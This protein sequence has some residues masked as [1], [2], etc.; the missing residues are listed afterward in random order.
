M[1]INPRNDPRYRVADDYL[2]FWLRF[3]EPSVADITRGRP[4]LALA[5][6]IGSWTDYRGQA[7]EPL[8]RK[9]LERLIAEDDDLHDVPVIG[10]YWT[11]A[12]DVE[13]DLVGPDRWPGATRIRL[14]GSIKWRENA[15]FGRRDLAGLAVHRTKVPGAADAVMIAVTRTECTTD[16]LD[17]VYGPADLVTAWEAP[18]RCG[19]GVSRRL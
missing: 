1:A 13:V 17:R 19:L 16:G 11:R 6:V 14:I 2:R 10:G 3:I 4:D 7:V 12:S 9:S 5:R 15:P 18:E 8:V